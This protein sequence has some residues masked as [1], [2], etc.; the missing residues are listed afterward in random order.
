MIALYDTLFVLFLPIS[1]RLDTS[2]D[3]SSLGKCFAAR[4]RTPQH[5]L[6]EI[7]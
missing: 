1:N 5:A 4:L 7:L 3:P 6:E 2:S